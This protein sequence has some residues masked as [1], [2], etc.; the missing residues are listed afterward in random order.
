MRAHAHNARTLGRTI[1]HAH[2]HVC[3]LTHSHVHTPS[4]EPPPPQLEYLEERRIKDL[5]KKHSEFIS[6]PIE[7]KV[8]KTVSKE[9][10]LAARRP[11][12]AWL[13]GGVCCGG[14]GRGAGWMQWGLEDAAGS[15]GCGDGRMQWV[16][17]LSHA[18]WC[19]L[20]NPH[21]QPTP[22]PTPTP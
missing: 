4:P 8:E 9:V 12:W 13:G 10:R 20:T 7:L 19:L 15:Q 17:Q 1:T 3:P 6:Y 11:R 2:T 5:V 18:S 21:P 16:W 14:V 22:T